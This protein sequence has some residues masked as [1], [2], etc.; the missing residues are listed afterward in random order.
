MFEISSYLLSIHCEFLWRIQDR[1]DDMCD[2]FLRSSIVHWT[3][4]WH[5]T[6]SLV[7]SAYTAKSLGSQICF[8]S[9]D[10]I[11]TKNDYNNCF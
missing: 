8:L 11:Q 5:P 6:P 9:R 3:T 7:V 2:G 1:C 4:W 10:R